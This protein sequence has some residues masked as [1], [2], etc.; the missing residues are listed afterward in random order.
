MLGAK[1]RRFI[2]LVL[3]TQLISSIYLTSAGRKTSSDYPTSAGH[4]YRR[5]IR[6]A[7]GVRYLYFLPSTQHPTII[8]NS[9]LVRIDG[10]VRC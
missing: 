5:F 7:L 2:Q 4:T 6:L 1:H 10:Q 3:G 9:M 8:L